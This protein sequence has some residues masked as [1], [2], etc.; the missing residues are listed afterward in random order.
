[1]EIDVMS[2]RWLSVEDIAEYLGVSKDTVYTW[3]N[4]RS[5]PAHRIGRLWKFKTDEIDGWVR[6]GGAAEPDSRA[7][8]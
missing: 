1:M 2:N 7:K 5:M 8:E 3:I 4:K 6:C